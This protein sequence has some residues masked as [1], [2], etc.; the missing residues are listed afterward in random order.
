[1]NGTTTLS[2]FIVG[3]LCLSAL[4]KEARIR[5]EEPSEKPQAMFSE[6]KGEIPDEP[7][8]NPKKIYTLEDGD[9]R[10]AFAN[11]RPYRQLWKSFREAQQ[12]IVSQMQ[13]FSHEASSGQNFSA[14]KRARLWAGKFLSKAQT[15]V[16]SC[17]PTLTINNTSK[18]KLQKGGPKYQQIQKSTENGRAEDTDEHTFSK[19]G[20]LESPDQYQHKKLFTRRNKRMKTG[21]IANIILKMLTTQGEIDDSLLL[22]ELF[23]P[24]NG[25]K[26]M[27]V[28]QPT[29]GYHVR[30]Q[31][32]GGYV[33]DI[34]PY[35]LSVAV[36]AR[37]IKNGK[38]AD[39]ARSQRFRTLTRGLSPAILR[40]GGTYANCVIYEEIAPED[41]PV[42]PYE[43]PLK[44]DPTAD[45]SFKKDPSLYL[46]RPRETDGIG[47]LRI[48]DG[49]ENHTSSHSCPFD[50]EFHSHYGVKPETDSKESSYDLLA[51]IFSSAYRGGSFYLKDE[52]SQFDPEDLLEARF[53]NITM[54]EEDLSVLTA[55][56]EDVGMTLLFD[57][58]QLYRTPDRSE[59]DPTNARRI[60]QDVASGNS[61]VIWQLGNEPNAYRHVFELPFSGQED[62]S[63]FE[64]F[65]RELNAYFDRPVIVGPDVT[66]PHKKHEIM[67]DGVE[68]GDTI[69]IH[70]V[71][72]LEDFLTNLKENLSAITWHHYYIDGRTATVDD[73]LSADLLNELPYSISQITRTRDHLAPATPIW[74]TETS[75]AYGGGAK[76][77]S[78]RYADG[79]LWMDKLGISAQMGV[80]V[81]ARQTLIY[82]SYALIDEYITPEPS[83]WLSYVFKKLV[84]E[85]VLNLT[86]K[87]ASPTTRLYAH[88]QKTS[89]IYSYQS[90]NIVIFGMNLDSKS[91]DVSLSGIHQ[92]HFIEQYLLEPAYGDLQ[93]NAIL[94]NGKALR[95]LSD[96]E[97]PELSSVRLP[98]QQFQIP[99]T[100]FGFWVFVK[101]GFEECPEEYEF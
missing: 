26:T 84:G 89:P 10:T 39:L 88:C 49:D 56:A 28:T 55:L 42:L 71:T 74:L 87:G 91:V 47:D 35:F 53:T 29:K 61:S 13:N 57:V 92:S 58:N 62:A 64:K 1:M 11:C 94:L 78:N 79:F 4:A 83:Y 96:E 43:E 54:T 34:P 50:K 69:Q 68:A 40:Y 65:H 30:A 98:E 45:E 46:T 75:S 9:L 2:L 67:A 85:R 90:G 48:G 93:S 72:F 25:N 12:D 23:S 14:L 81:V 16:N 60:F 27:K 63:D 36:G 70:P 18:P 21:R 44:D 51:A 17:L 15:I 73:F 3:S 31:I 33:R 80:D 6:A 82:D 100:T 76:N 101:A 22:K 86:M 95:M 97:L 20:D 41:S 32:K 8:K 99:P 37:I 7:A 5:Y 38:L 24:N 66:N 59:W 19:F 77:L 52:P